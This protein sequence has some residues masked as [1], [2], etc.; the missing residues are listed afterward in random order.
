MCLLCAFCD[1]FLLIVSNS[2]LLVFADWVDY[3]G[4][5]WGLASGAL[6][7]AGLMGELLHRLLQCHLLLLLLYHRSSSDQG[8]TKRRQLSNFKLKN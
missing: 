2:C 6:G 5:A 7:A 8:K 4:N 3:G 1:Y